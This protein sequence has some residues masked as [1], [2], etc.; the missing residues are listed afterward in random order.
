MG[1]VGYVCN[2]AYCGDV[3]Q[4]GGCAVHDGACDYEVGCATDPDD[5]VSG[6]CAAEP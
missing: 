4:Y 3:G 1:D 5:P 2:A 6:E